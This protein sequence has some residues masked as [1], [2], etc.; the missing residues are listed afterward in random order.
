METS[1][2]TISAVQ[3]EMALFTGI[4]ADF[5]PFLLVVACFIESKLF[6]MIAISIVW[7]FIA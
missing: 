1:A 6:Y 4:S 3:H 7:D 2:L 5:D